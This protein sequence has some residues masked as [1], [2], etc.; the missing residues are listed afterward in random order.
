MN[1]KNSG[2]VL[3]IGI[4]A[5]ESTLVLELMRQG[6]MPALARLTKQGKWLRIDSPAH[7]GSGAVWPTFLTGE[8]PSTHGI[9]GEWRWN[10]QAMNLTRYNGRNLR[11]FWK[12]LADDNLTVG[13]LDVPFAP[14]VGL[15]RGFEILEWGAHDRAE[16][17]MQITPDA[18]A[19]W[20]TKEFS[21]HPFSTK[22]LEVTG[23]DDDDGL[24]KLTDACLHGVKLRGALAQALLTKYQPDLSIIIFP[25]IHQSG[26]SLWHTVA[27]QDELYKSEAF[28]APR[29]FNRSLE[30]IYSEVDRQVG[31]LIDTAG[32]QAAVVVFSLHGMQPI[33]G[34]PAFLP[35][36]LREHGFAHLAGWKTKSWRERAV[37]FMAAAKRRAPSGLRRLYYSAFSRNTTSWLA[38][39]TML[40]VYDWSRTRAFSLPTDQHGVIRINLA[41][42]ESEGI[43]PLGQYRELCQQLRDLFLGLVTEDGEPVVREVILT[44]AG[45]H[46]PLQQPIP[47]L[48]V[49]WHK[50]A[51]AEGAKIKNSKVRIS[52]E[53]KRLTGHHAFEG[54]CILRDAQD[55]QRDSLRAKEMHSLIREMISKTRAVGS[56]VAVGPSQTHRS[57]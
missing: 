56:T 29:A 45:A 55:I 24:T 31:T 44:A 35:A 23:P 51:F 1:R 10:P 7:I 50:G 37:S 18:V 4:D 8:E 41:G 53:A 39:P 27:P 43:V 42:R 11:P 25:E 38:Q 48:I 12:E 3:A 52:G 28:K 15:K 22:R 32:D 16:G 33:R 9:Y 13:I 6:K 14:P 17:R 57:E 36:L 54:F 30:E 19:E 34:L 47:D 5:A 21:T 26:H 2:S 46:D 40:P 49:H 20:V